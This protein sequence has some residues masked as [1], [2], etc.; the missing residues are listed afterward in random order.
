MKKIIALA[1]SLVMVLSLAAC[2]SDPADSSSDPPSTEIQHYSLGTAS[3]G[4]MMYAI[5]SGW[6]NLMNNVLGD[7]YQFTSE[8]TAGN[9]ANIAMIESG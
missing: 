3:S 6:A 5:G 2:G 1:L 7:K 9:N 4:G 8:E